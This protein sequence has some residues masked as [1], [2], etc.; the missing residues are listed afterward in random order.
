MQILAKPVNKFRIVR[1]D[2]QVT[3]V[4][5]ESYYLDMNNYYMFTTQTIDEVNKLVTAGKVVKSVFDIHRRHVLSV[6]AVGAAVHTPAPRRRAPTRSK[7][8]TK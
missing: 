3:E 5:A 1:T 2:G 6:E 4:E 7:K 8:K